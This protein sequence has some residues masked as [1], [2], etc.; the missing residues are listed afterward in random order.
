MVILVAF[1]LLFLKYRIARLFI[2]RNKVADMYT[3]QDEHMRRRNELVQ[4]EAI[5]ANN[6]VM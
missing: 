1:T 6:D 4:E 2:N 5:G 3:T